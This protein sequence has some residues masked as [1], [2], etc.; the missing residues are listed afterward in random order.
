MAGILVFGVVGL[1]FVIGIIGL[2]FII[3]KKEDDE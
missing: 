1:V 3:A 2:V